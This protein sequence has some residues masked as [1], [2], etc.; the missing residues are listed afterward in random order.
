MSKPI[1][2]PTTPFV[3]SLKKDCERLLKKF[4]KRSR[5]KKATAIQRFNEYLVKLYWRYKELSLAQTEISTRT[6]FNLKRPL[7]HSQLDF[8]DKLEIFYQGLY[9]TISAFSML[10]NHTAPPE[11]RKDMPIRSAERFIRFMKKNSSNLDA[12]WDLLEKARDFRIKFIDHIQQHVLHDWMT[13]S[14]VRGGAVVIYFIPEDY[15]NPVYFT[16]PLDPLD[17]NFIPPVGN[18]GFYVSPPYKDVYK[19]LKKTVKSH[20][21]IISSI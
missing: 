17:P 2:L 6:P 21:K 14:T 13:Y 9:A 3:Q 16:E 4:D 20:L 5:G 19:A 10:L 1:N 11:Y 18:R 12:E 15:P 7:S 8:V